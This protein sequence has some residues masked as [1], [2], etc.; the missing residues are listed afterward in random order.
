MNSHELAK[1]LLEYPDMP[2]AVSANNHEY[3]ST[4]SDFKIAL[5]HHYSGEFLMIGNMGKMDLNSP[6]WYLR[7]V[8]YGNKLPV[9][10]PRMVS[11]PPKWEFGES[12]DEFN[13]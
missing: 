12:V 13:L 11:Q 1:L 5:A 4:E 8:L 9:N 2:I 6:N 3:F 10:Y 7:K